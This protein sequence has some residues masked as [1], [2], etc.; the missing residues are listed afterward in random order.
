MRQFI[1][2]DFLRD[3]G[4][5]E[6]GRGRFQKV[7]RGIVTAEIVI[8]DSGEIVSAFGVPM[9]PNGYVYLYLR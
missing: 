7:H 4:F 1:R 9:A 3:M 2:A 8:R 6:V 5:R